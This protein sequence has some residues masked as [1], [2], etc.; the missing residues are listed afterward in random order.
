MGDWSREEV[1]WFGRGGHTAELPCG[2]F[3]ACVRACVRVGGG[4]SA[5]TYT[6]RER[7]AIGNLRGAR[8]GGGGG[9]KAHAY[10]ERCMGNWSRQQVS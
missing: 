3:G 8:G 9:G 5:S 6:L 2:C 10:L 4:G 1:G 7:Y